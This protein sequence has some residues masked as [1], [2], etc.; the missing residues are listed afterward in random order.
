MVTARSQFK[1][2]IRKCKLEIDK[3]E[4]AKLAQARF[5]NA[6][7]YWSMLKQSANVK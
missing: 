1:T 7:L 3:G 4:T 6:K 2:C 5:K